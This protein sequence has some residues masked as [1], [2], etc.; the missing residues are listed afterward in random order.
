MALEEIRDVELLGDGV[1]FQYLVFSL[2][3]EGATKRIARGSNYI[4]SGVDSEEALIRWTRQDLEDAGFLDAGGEFT[5]QGGGSL[6]RNP[7]YGTLTLFGKNTAY[8][9]DPDRE[10][11][12]QT[13]K[14]EF[15]DY[16]VSWF[17]PDVAPPPKS[18][19]RVKRRRPAKRRRPMKRRR[20]LK[21][22]RAK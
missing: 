13:F 22:R 8:G 16:E 21:S 11:L 18:R 12:A 1:V 20:P 19:P 15:P 10:S 4:S 7:Y 5:V 6:A 17:G 2:Q 14:A 9:A 3:L